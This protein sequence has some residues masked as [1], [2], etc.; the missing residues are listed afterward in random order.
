MSLV[1]SP[2][3]SIGL[4]GG[5]FDPPHIGHLLLAECARRE[6]GLD[7]VLF[8]PAGEPYRKTTPGDGTPPPR[9]VSASNHRLAMTELAVAGNPHFGVDAR[10][11]HRAGNTYTIDTL[12][13]LRAE[14][15]DAKPRLVLILGSDA[16]ADMPYWKTPERL[17]ELA[18]IVI[19]RK[20]SLGP[21]EIATEMPVPPTLLSLLRVR[22]PHRVGELLNH[23]HLPETLP[24]VS[25]MPTLP[26]SSTL[27][28]Q[29]V[30]DG[31]PVQYLVPASVET[32][33]AAHGLYDRAGFDS[34]SQEAEHA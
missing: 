5:T 24:V 19:A 27:I 7:R 6:F 25:M 29:R 28:R 8:I 1:L 17:F 13:S 11:V 16:L 14:S 2:K 20:G 33:I 23:E 32:Y 26:I 3:S 9:T 15:G 34:N 31:L 22:W 30:A 18:S 12:E 4:L 10:E 21:H